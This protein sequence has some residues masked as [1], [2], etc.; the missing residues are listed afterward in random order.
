MDI[1]YT[2]KRLQKTGKTKNLS[3]FHLL[4]EKKVILTEMF[5]QLHSTNKVV[6]QK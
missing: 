6:S 3:K 1:L 2:V 5:I 4:R